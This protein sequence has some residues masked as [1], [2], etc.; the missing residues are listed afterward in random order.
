MSGH[1]LVVM[2]N[3]KPGRVS[4]SMDASDYIVGFFSPIT[5]R[6]EPSPDRPGAASVSAHAES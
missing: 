5:E 4:D 1:L 2:S 3:A 6:F